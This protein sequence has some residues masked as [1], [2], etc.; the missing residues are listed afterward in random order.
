MDTNNMSSAT[1]GM[2]ASSTMGMMDMGNFDNMMMK[3]GDGGMN[4]MMGMRND[5]TRMSNAQMPSAGVDPRDRDE[6]N[7]FQMQFQGQHGNNVNN[8]VNRFS[9]MSLGSAFNPE[10]PL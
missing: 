2:G 1:M 7:P 4:S 5:P 9:D 8:V 3:D 10:G 6:R